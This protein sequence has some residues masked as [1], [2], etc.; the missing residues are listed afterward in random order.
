MVN[1]TT[2]FWSSTITFF[3]LAIWCFAHEVRDGAFFFLL[4]CSIFLVGASILSEI[5]DK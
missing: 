4:L 2:L 5:K 1:T 3:V